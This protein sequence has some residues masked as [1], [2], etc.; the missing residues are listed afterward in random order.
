MSPIPDRVANLRAALENDRL[1]ATLH[2]VGSG[3]ETDR[4]G[5]DDD[6]WMLHEVL[7]H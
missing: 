1:D 3:G 5:S 7:L 2:E 4:S 6:D